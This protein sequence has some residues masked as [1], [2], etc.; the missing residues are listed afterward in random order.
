MSDPGAVLRWRAGRRPRRRVAGSSRGPRAPRRGALADRLAGELVRVAGRGG[1][2][3]A[4]RRRWLRARATSAAASRSLAVERRRARARRRPRSPTGCGAPWW[5]G[6]PSLDARQR[7][8]FTGLV[9]GDDRDQPADLADDFR[10]AGPHPPA[11]RVGAERG[12]RARRWPVRCCARLRLWPRLRRHARGDRALR[13]HDP[14]RAVGAA[15][16]RRWRRWRP[17]VAMAGRPVRR[18]A[19]ARPRRRRA[20][21]R[22]PAA[23]PRRSASSCRSA[24]GRGHRRARPPLG[25]GAARARRGCA[26]RWRSRWRPSSAWRRCCSPRSGRCRW[27]RSRPTCWP[28]PA[29]GLVMVWGLTGGLV[30]RRGRRARRPPCSTCPT[31]LALGWLDV[32]ADA[33]GRGAPLGDARVPRT[34]SALAL[35]VGVGASSAAPAALSPGGRSAWR[36]WRR[37]SRPSWPPTAPPPLRSAPA[38]GVVRWHGG[39]DRRRG[40]RRR[41]RAPRARRRAVARRR[42]AAAGVGRIDLL[43]VADAVRAGG[44]RRARCGA[45]AR[46]RPCS[47]TG[48]RLAVA[49]RAALEPPPRRVDGRRRRT[50]WPVARGRCRDRLVV[51]AVPR[52]REPVGAVGPR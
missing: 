9:L 27:R 29:A 1:A 20:G 19:G 23:R 39:G 4:G 52:R 30:G 24:R 3:A 44:R 7:S 43:V 36:R 46:R 37:R 11:R 12:L 6:T 42:C 41:R 40:A 49:G 25:R 13:R 34:S 45:P 22:R 38:A 5:P 16:R 2:G 17:T 47:R 21:A 51:E 35:A 32:V 50:R 8:L 31:R 15:G 26:S 48:A 28:C 10:G 14:V 18:A 33:R